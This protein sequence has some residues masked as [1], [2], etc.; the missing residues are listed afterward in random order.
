MNWKFTGL[1]YWLLITLISA[2][3]MVPLTD[4]EAARTCRMGVSSV[5]FGNYTPATPSPVDSAGT[6][7]VLCWGRPSRGQGS[8]YVLRIDGGSSG[9]P[10]TRSMQAGGGPL[11]YNL[12]KNASRTNIWGD[13]TAGTTPLIQ[14]L[15]G[16]FFFFRNHPVYG[17]VS[18]GQDPTPGVYG[19]IPMVTIEF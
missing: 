6:V 1:P 4:A 3:L 8:F 17:R 16:R 7:R 18:A 14:N 11:F 13:G 5:A 12:Y 10:A 9:T 2:L 15:P 19:D